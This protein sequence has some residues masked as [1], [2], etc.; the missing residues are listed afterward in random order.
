MNKI[1]FDTI[2]LNQG[3]FHCFYAEIAKGNNCYSKDWTTNAKQRKRSASYADESRNRSRGS[4][5]V[6]MLS[7]N[8]I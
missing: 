3:N 5:Q 6:E 2:R 8:S 7:D 1:D 4:T